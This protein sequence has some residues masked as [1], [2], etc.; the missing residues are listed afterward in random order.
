MRSGYAESSKG[1]REGK[2]GISCPS[3][4]SIRRHIRDG[5]SRR[6][7]SLLC[8]RQRVGSELMLVVS[9]TEHKQVAS[10]DVPNLSIKY[11]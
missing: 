11:H 10:F 3:L 9:V 6:A 5:V 2:E 8:W 1:G 7:M 4:S